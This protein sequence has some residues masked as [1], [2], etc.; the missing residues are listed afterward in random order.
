MLAVK[1][2]RLILRQWRLEDK[3][4][5]AAINADPRV[6]E[7]FPNKLSGSQ[8]DALIE[9]FS[10]DIDASG[11]GF[12]AAER[13][14]S[15]EFIGFV[16]INYNLDGLPF[17]PCVDIGWRLGSQHWGQGLATEAAQGAIAFAFMQTDLEQ[18]VSITSVANL[19]SERVMQKLGMSKQANNFLHPK[20][21]QG[22]RLEEHVLYTIRRDRWLS[23]GV[24]NNNAK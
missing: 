22:H 16:G 24:V 5:F 9:R 6:M 3:P 15:G 17:A 10:G 21:A 4:L 14:D 23:Q 8:S 7:Y 20:I 11:W 13:V 1:T 12:W 19:A 18:L 2:E